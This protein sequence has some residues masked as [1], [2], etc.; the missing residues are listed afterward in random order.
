MSYCSS[1]TRAVAQDNVT[2]VQVQQC[3]KHTVRHG[4]RYAPVFLEIRL[5]SAINSNILFRI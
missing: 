1:E 4:V 3:V 2:L 5:W